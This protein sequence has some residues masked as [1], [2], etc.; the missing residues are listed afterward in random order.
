M[1]AASGENV[2]IDR[3]IR[4]G[5]IIPT[6]SRRTFQFVHDYI[7][8]ATFSMVP[9]ESRKLTYHR[10]GTLILKNSSKLEMD[11]NLFTIVN[12]L[13]FS[14]DEQSADEKCILAKL[15]FKA[16][17]KTISLVAF[18]SAMHFLE[19]A[20]ELQDEEDCWIDDYDFSLRLFLVAAETAYS[21]VQY[22]KMEQFLDILIENVINKDDLIPPFCLKINSLQYTRKSGEALR[23]GLKTLAHLDENLPAQPGNK[24]ML[25]AMQMIYEIDEKVSNMNMGELKTIDGKKALALQV[26]YATTTAAYFTNP[27]LVS[28]IAIRIAQLTVDYGM[29]KYSAL[30]FALIGTIFCSVND[31][32]RS[33]R[34]GNIS[35]SIVETFRAKDLLPKVHMYVYGMIFHFKL[36]ILELWKHLLHTSEKALQVGDN[37]TSG[38]C[39][40]ISYYYALHSGKNLRLL[41]IESEKFEKI[42]RER[43]N[44][45]KQNVY[46][47]THQAVLNLTGNDCCQN[48]D[49]LTGECFD[50]R[51]DVCFDNPGEAVRG[52]LHCIIM[53]YMFHRYDQALQWIEQCKPFENYYTFCLLQ[54]LFTF[55]EGL[56]YLAIVNNDPCMKSYKRKAEECIHSFRKWSQ[57]CPINYSNKLMLLEAEF[58]VANGSSAK[59]SIDLYEKSISL[60][61]EYGYIHES[62]LA[63]ERLAISMISNLS[64]P[65]S[66]LREAFHKYEKWGALTKMIHLKKKFSTYFN[67]SIPLAVGLGEI[68][69]IDDAVSEIT[70]DYGASTEVSEFKSK[71]QRTG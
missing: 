5:L 59:K 35:L 26:Y 64:D 20:I 38:H 50:F 61:K 47:S 3:I 11:D 42:N 9:E 28:L 55:Y 19:K 25:K 8:K 37:E 52:L 31:Y 1:K 71:V 67:E 40:S 21:L 2:E 32:E 27:N 54:T 15:N 4:D 23:L 63:Y 24:D 17:K 33:Y 36:P 70:N 45:E 51:K 58:S 14:S 68:Q 12:M 69:D 56:T 18:H 62:A 66:Y 39:L 53:A 65:S 10:L 30:G 7:R 48:P 44:F 49:L 6:N 41:L 29:F 16:A 57:S 46:K 13:N 22:D 43:A 60:S 34:F